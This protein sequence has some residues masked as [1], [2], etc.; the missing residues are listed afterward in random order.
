M[1]DSQIAFDICGRPLT[2]DSFAARTIGRRLVFYDNHL[3]LPAAIFLKPRWRAESRY[4]YH[5]LGRPK[6]GDDP[7]YW[8]YGRPL[9]L[10]GALTN[11]VNSGLLFA[12]KPPSCWIAKVADRI[13]ASP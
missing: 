11:T 10:Q 7:I 1:R 3:R 4:G 2:P 6:G 8:R 13:L 9:L 5:E 12:R